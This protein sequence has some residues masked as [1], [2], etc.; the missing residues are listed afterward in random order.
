MHARTTWRSEIET[1][2]GR[3]TFPDRKPFP[4]FRIA[5]RPL[6]LLTVLVSLCVIVPVAVVRGL[7]DFAIAVV[8]TV[9]E[10]IRRNW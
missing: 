1:L 5:N 9:Q 8:W 4:R 10:V 2:P 3:N 6:R 7:I